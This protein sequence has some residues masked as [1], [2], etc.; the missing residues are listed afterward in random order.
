MVLSAF[1]SLIAV[2]RERL[3]LV[4]S[5]FTQEPSLS[6]PDGG[7]YE[8]IQVHIDGSIRVW[9]AII[10][11]IIW[12]FIRKGSHVGNSQISCRRISVL[13]IDFCSQKKYTQLVLFLLH[14]LSEHG[15]VERKDS[16][17]IG[18]NSA[19]AVSNRPVWQEKDAFI[20][21]SKSGCGVI[22]E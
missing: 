22:R 21:S 6:S 17:S 11:G 2:W 15:F 1:A 4:G 16:L 19:F 14:F 3:L 7:S 9:W 20:P 5:T 13:L 8:L 10:L 18:K 12:G